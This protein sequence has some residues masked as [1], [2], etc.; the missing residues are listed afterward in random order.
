MK[1]PGTCGGRARIGGHRV[2]VQDIVIWHEHQGMTPDEIVSQIPSITLADVH[3]ALAYYFD[4][5]QEIQEEMRGDRAYAEEFRRNHPSLLD[6]KLSREP[7][8]EAS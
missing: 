4:H 2:R 1:T 5:V 3:S 6:E 7:L 8:K